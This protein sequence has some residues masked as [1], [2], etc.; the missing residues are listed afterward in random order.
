MSSSSSNSFIDN[1]FKLKE[2]GTTVT[3]EV[4]AGITI[5]LSMAYILAVNPEL[6]GIAGLDRGAVFTATAV[7][8]SVACL[9]MGFLANLPI[10]L[11]PGMGLNAFFTFTVVISMK[12][13]VETALTAV[14]LEGILFI[15][16]SLF[17]VREAILKSIPTN[18]KKAIPSGIGLFIAFIGL[19]SAGIIVDNEATLVSLAD[20]TTPSVILA[21]AGIILT[22]VLF[23][24]N[25]TGGILLGILTITIIGYGTGVVNADWT[26]FSPVSLPHKPAFWMF[27]FSQVLTFKFFIV[28]FSFLFVDVFD[29]VGTFVGVAAQ[30]K[31]HDKN[32]NI[33][34]IKQAFLADA[35]GTCVGATLGTSTVTSYVE[36]T[37]GVAVGGRTGL[38]AIVVSALFLLSLFFSPLFLLIP[39]QATASA[40]VMVGFLMMRTIKDVEFSDATEGLPAFLTIVMMPLAYSIAQGI[41]FGI[42]SYVLLKVLTGKGKSVHSVTWVLF[43]IFILQFFMK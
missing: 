37:S 33:P 24:L 11:A 28:F 29:T 2:R 35:V 42:L 12:Y 31:L 17:N 14:F 9:L 8:A 23:A 38:T 10:A 30:S 41:V 6:L 16:F 7:S 20:L 34:H 22:V 26:N 21:I 4:L 3:T 18:L 27:D 43:I 1:F 32:G 19:K 39:P 15:V 13:S 25:V 36:S 5:F 40:L